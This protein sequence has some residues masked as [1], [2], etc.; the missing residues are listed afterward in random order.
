[1]GTA[2]GDRR[3]VADA[4]RAVRERVADDAY[5]QRTGDICRQPGVDGFDRDV[6]RTQFA[7]E[8]YAAFAGPLVASNRF[9]IRVQAFDHA[10][11]QVPRRMHGSM[12]SA[13][14]PIKLQS[15]FGSGDE[16]GCILHM[17]IHYITVVHHMDDPCG[18]DPPAISPLAAA[19]CVEDGAVHAH[20][21]WLTGQAFKDRR[22]ASQ[23]CR[24]SQILLA[25]HHTKPPRQPTRAGLIRYFS[26]VAT[27]P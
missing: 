14:V 19:L 24:F 6:L 26:P 18:P 11:Q 3:V 1:M 13:P 4:Y 9:Q 25:G 15:H 7:N 12:Q 21:G 27:F 22:C 10:C 5:R 8:L 2:A 23:A 20:D 17:V 16:S